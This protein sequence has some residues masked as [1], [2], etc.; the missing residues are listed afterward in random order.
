MTKIIGGIVGE[1]RASAG[2]QTNKTQS[3]A[4]LQ[5]PPEETPKERGRGGQV[6]ARR[7]AF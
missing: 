3:T 7:R 6:A 1:I 2:S 5:T 4:A